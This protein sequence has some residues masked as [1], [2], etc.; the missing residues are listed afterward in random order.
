[1]LGSGTVVVGGKLHCSILSRYTSVGEGAV[2]DESILF[3]DVHLA[4]GA[5]VR[6][7]I[8]DKHVRVPA[9]ER[10]G[11][12]PQLDRKRF[13]VSEAGVVVVPKGYCFQK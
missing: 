8:I 1:M 9:G 4:A 5:E 6:K 7:A 3:D 2:V 13:T 10:I 12:D 11:V